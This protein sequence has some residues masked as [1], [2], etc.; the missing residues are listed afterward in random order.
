MFD[1]LLFGCDSLARTKEKRSLQ[2]IDGFHWV[3]AHH[4]SGV[5]TIQYTLQVQIDLLRCYFKPFI[6]NIGYKLMKF[7]TYSTLGIRK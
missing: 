3:S 1:S 5:E 2:L 7:C 4:E 6:S